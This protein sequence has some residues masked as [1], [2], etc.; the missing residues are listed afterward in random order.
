MFAVSLSVFPLKSFPLLILVANMFQI[1]AFGISPW[2]SMLLGLYSNV[3]GY[4]SPASATNSPS[5]G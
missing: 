1:S 3:S 5:E 4:V 2:S